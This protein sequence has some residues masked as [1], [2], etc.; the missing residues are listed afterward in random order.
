MEPII[1]TTS[2]THHMMIFIDDS[3][4]NQNAAPVGPFPCDGFPFE[5]SNN[6]TYA[7]YVDGWFPGRGLTPMPDGIGFPVENGDRLILQVHYDGVSAPHQDMSGIRLMLD[8]RQ[9]Y[10]A[11][12]TLW[13]GVIWGTPL[14]GQD[15]RMGECTVTQD[16]TIFRSAPHMHQY[17]V[18]IV[19][20]VRRAG[21]QAYEV[22][23]EIP[24]WNVEDQPILD[25]PAERQL[26][27]A[28]DTLRTRCWWDTGGESV[29][30]GDASDDEMCFSIYF[31]YPPHPNTGP[32]GFCVTQ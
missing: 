6:G 30:Q 26:I 31:A 10:T 1:D 3:G 8:E 13:N 24:A 17:G 32:G 7:E 2:N 12:G 21:S 15:M 11:A 28:G 9:I 4:A 25:V 5:A 29:R 20:D 16:V 22:L 18:R 27:R 14:M 23:A 19:G